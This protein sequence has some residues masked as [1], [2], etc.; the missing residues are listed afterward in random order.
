M[1]VMPKTSTP[2][3]KERAVRPVLEHQQAYPSLSATAEVVAK[4][5]GV[6]MESVR[7]LVTQA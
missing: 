4:Q 5:M 6:G 3:L 2:Q 1:R 7:L